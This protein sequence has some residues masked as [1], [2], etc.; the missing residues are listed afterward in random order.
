[1]TPTDRKKAIKAAKKIIDDMGI[2]QP[3]VPVEKIARRLAAQVRYSP[4]DD[5]LS[6]MIFIKEDKP[7]IGVNALH[8]PNRQRF[9][10]AHEIGHLSLHR[11]HISKEVHVDKQFPVLMRD[12]N[13]A[14]GVDS[15][16]IEANG[17][18]S[19]L[20][21]P[22]DLVMACLKDSSVDIDDDGFITKL[23]KKFKVSPQ[24]MQLRLGQILK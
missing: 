21:M 3:P 23:A 7:I 14:T 10:I 9:T 16:E 12:A 4:L 15:I 5:E 8:H 20:L 6:G 17:F 1:M 11:D 2:T 18:A 22:E 19:E 13:A 24:A